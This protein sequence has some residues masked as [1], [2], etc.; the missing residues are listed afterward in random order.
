MRKIICLGVL[1]FLP[2]FLWGQEK[3]EKIE[4]EGNDRVTKETILYYLS[5]REG[6]YFSRKI[7][8]DDFHV[9]WSTGFFSDIKMEE[10]DGSTGKVI[11]IHVKEN[12]LIKEIIYNTKGKKLKEDDIVSKLKENDEYILP[13]SYY[14]QYKVQRIKNTILDLLAEK[15]LAGGDVRTDLIPREAG[16]LQLV[17]NIKEGH[18]IK[19]GEVVF[20]GR[21]KVREGRLLDSMKENKRHNL[22]TWI[23]GKD[24]YKQSKLSEDLQNLKDKYHELGYME[25]TI[26]EP[27][28]EEITRKT[29]FF[30]TQ[31]MKKI[32][33]P[34]DAG[35]RYFV[36]DVK[37]EGSKIF[38]AKALLKL[39]PLEEGEIYSTKAREKAI[40][41]IRKLYQDFGHLYAQV[42]PIESL[43]PKHK[44]AHVTFQIYEGEIVY[45]RRLQFRGN[46]YTKDKVIRRE[47]PLREGEPFRMGLLEN[48]ILRMKQI[49]LVEM[50]NQPEF[51]TDPDDPTQMDIIINLKELQ[52][53]NIQFTAGYSG[54]EGTFVGLSYSTVNFLGAG[55]QLDITFQHGKRYKDYSF[56]FREPYF[57][58]YPISVGFRVFNRK[59]N[60]PYLYDRKDKGIEFT[61]G[62]RIKG[63]WQATLMYNYSYVNI[64]LP[65]GEQDG[66]NPYYYYDPIYYSMFGLG[67]Y[68]IS[69]ITPMIY[70]STVNSPL[71][72][73]EGTLYQV[74]CKLAGTFLG[75]EIDLL[76][77]QFVFTH[78]QPIYS[79]HVLGF[80]A[81]YPFNKS[82]GDSEIPFWARFYLGGER[83]I[84]G[85]DFYTVGP[86]SEQGTNIGG[87]KAFFFN[88]EYIIPVGGPLYTIFFYDVGN[89]YLSDQKINLKDVFSSAGLELRVFVP[90]LRV[91]FRLI[92]S[93]NNRK[94]RPDD[95]NFAFRFAIGT[96]F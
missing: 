9:L 20:E 57:L 65:T 7:L 1:V 45:L 23:A 82:L 66:Y 76:K 68:H 90:A 21:L 18:K 88:F 71:T 29:I 27:R 2:L 79:N 83:S 14:N 80:H 3:V 24:T 40:E 38:P 91:P 32:V 58:D 34:V 69:G 10:K 8:R 25:A 42:R 19:V 13:N 35:Y 94:A 74:S 30:K 59:L 46:N 5:S 96:S 52:R 43:D 55:E 93:Y 50:E 28:I 92:F 39:V 33:I 75:G 6:D 67:N 36:G 48:S 63:Y 81:E 62:A 86:R 4:I 54:W 31:T 49:G 51:K 37:I 70:R 22:F 15:G 84:R 78:F 12:P 87:D 53:N 44:I 95:S 26:G 41:D 17:F 72:P 60:Y 73:T 77:P 16:G 47:F 11:V 64:E 89:S 56:G 85:Y 61:L